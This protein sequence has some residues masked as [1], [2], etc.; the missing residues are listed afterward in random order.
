MGIKAVFLTYQIYTALLGVRTKNFG[1]DE[2]IAEKVVKNPQE[3]RGFDVNF[4]R[5]DRNH[6]VIILPLS[7][8]YFSTVFIFGREKFPEYDV[9]GDMRVTLTEPSLN[10]QF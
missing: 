5:A 10:Q 7:I 2:K 1:S 8:G 6:V 3:Q 4:L 9:V